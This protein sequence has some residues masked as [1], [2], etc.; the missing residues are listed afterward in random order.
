MK[1]LDFFQLLIVQLLRKFIEIFL[2]NEGAGD[3]FLGLTLEKLQILNSQLS[4]GKEQNLNILQ[5][6][7]VSVI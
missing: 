1:L 6:S 4:Q 3:N 7:F 2:K 5:I